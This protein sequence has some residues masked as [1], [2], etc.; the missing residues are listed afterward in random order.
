ME[1]Q[2]GNTR[3]LAW[4]LLGWQTTAVSTVH[5]PMFVLL[6]HSLPGVLKTPQNCRFG[7]FGTLQ[8]IYYCRNRTCIRI[9]LEKSLRFSLVRILGLAVWRCSVSNLTETGRVQHNLQGFG[10]LN[11]TS[12]YTISVHYCVLHFVHI[13]VAVCWNLC[14]VFVVIFCAMCI[15]CMQCAVCA[16]SNMCDVWTMC[17]VQWAISAMCGQFKNVRCE[18]CVDNVQVRFTQWASNRDAAA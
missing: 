3:P 7:F 5:T 11:P 2:G 6:F 17:I 9:W 10:S 14:E 1:I 4:K 13:K 8:C 18:R 12:A 15:V 16:M